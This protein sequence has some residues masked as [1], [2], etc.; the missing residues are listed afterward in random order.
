MRRSLFAGLIC[1]LCTSTSDSLAQTRNAAAEER[2]VYVTYLLLHAVGSE[3]YSVGA[4]G[5]REAVMTIASTL[6]DRGTTRASTSTLTMGAGFAPVR[7]ELKR[8]GAPADET[9]RTEVGA[10][11]ATV[12]EPGASRTLNKPAVAYVGFASMPAA[13][14]MMMMRYWTLHHEPA[15]L[16]ILRASEKALPL[17]VR[18]V[19]EDLVT[20]PDHRVR[21]TRY[22]VAN[23]MFGREILWMDGK[24]RLAALMTF[25]GGLPQEQVLQA[26]APAFEQLVRSGVRQEMA[27]LDALGRQVT[28]EASGAFAIVG[29]RLIDGTGAP[30]IEDSVVIVRDGRIAAVGARGSVAMPAGIKVIRANGQSLLPGLWEMH[31]HYS[32]VE[33]GPALLAAGVTTARDCGGEFDFLTTVRRKIDQE[34][35]L[36][37]RL[38]MAGLIDSGGPLAFGAVDAET[39]AEG[40]AA[41]DRYADAHFDQIKVYTQVKPDVLKAISAEAHRRGLTVTGHVPAAVDA[42]EGIADG[43][44][45][46]NHLQFV[47]R[48]MQSPE[49]GGGGAGPVDLTSDR[50][51]NLIALMRARQTVVDPTDG[52]GEMAGHPKTVRA[53]SFEPGLDAAPFTLASKFEAMGA[54]VEESRFRERIAAN[55]RVIDALYKAGVPIV[56]GSDTGLIGYGIDRELELY[57]QAGL[58]PIAAIQTATLGAARAMKLDRDS[59]SIEVGKRAD[60]MLV[61]GNPLANIS[62]LR[63]VVKVVRGGQLYDSQALG[64]SVGFARTH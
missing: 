26:Y 35:A 52:W 9:W 15:S 45:Q 53:A 19:G 50:A 37:P 59:G 25:A 12:Q 55:G 13:L 54:P 8:E 3:T 57:V 23:L 31:S 7:L 30:A 51:K 17:E 10:A 44:D 18:R 11:S 21:L 34:H 24:G 39:P 64:R 14:Q 20:L 48:A 29:A 1:L 27:N 56:A 60:L 22:T 5:P 63:R 40:V 62:D 32:G 41:V 61:E 33:F 47:T 46:I 16:P 4:P 38:L 58:P 28:P 42:F 2:G 49:T 43:M 6:S 36:G